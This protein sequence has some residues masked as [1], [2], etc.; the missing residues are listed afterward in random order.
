MLGLQVLFNAV[1]ELVLLLLQDLQARS[2]LRWESR[3]L[4]LAGRD[5]TAAGGHGL[6]GQRKVLAQFTGDGTGISSTSMMSFSVSC[7]FTLS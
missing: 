5:A 3:L 6:H 7:G 4:G 2:R 1:V